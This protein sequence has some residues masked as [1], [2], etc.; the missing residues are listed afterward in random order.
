MAR[1]KDDPK[2]SKAAAGIIIPKLDKQLDNERGNEILKEIAELKDY[3]IKKSIW[4]FG[5]DGWAY[6]IGFGGLD[7]VLLQEKM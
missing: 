2:E 5:G 1:R 6:D 4:I 7:H 3:L